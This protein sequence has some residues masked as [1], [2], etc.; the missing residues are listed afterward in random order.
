MNALKNVVGIFPKGWRVPLGYRRDGK[1]HDT[2]VR[3]MGVHT[4]ANCWRKMEGTFRV[5]FRNR[6]DPKEDGKPGEEPKPDEPKPDEERPSPIRLKEAAKSP[7]PK[8]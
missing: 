5:K 3:L 4:E 6:G 1:N 8:N 7:C 2:F